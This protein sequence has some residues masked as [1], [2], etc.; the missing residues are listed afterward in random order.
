MRCLA[1]AVLLVACG[2]HES[3]IDHYEKAPAADPWA[4][5]FSKTGKPD[6]DSG[7]DLQG[8]L[9]KIRDSI[10]TPGPYEAPEK[11]ADYDEQ[12]PHWGVMKLSGSVVER[13][14]FSFTGGHGT[15]LRELAQR[16]RT[17]AKDDKLLGLVV[18]GVL[19]RSVQAREWRPRDSH[20]WLRGPRPQIR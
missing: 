17:L 7:F 11:S 5:T 6:D 16:L 10:E 4:A 14:T 3:A 20:D 13:E 9:A 12:K 1:V 2:H 15:E 8:T 19:Q 18:T